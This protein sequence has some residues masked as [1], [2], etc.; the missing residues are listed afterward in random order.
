MTQIIDF[1]INPKNSGFGPFWG[2]KNF[3]GKFGSITHSLI[4]FSSTIPKF[5]KVND[6]IRRKR[7]DRRM[8]GRK[9]GRTDR[10]YF[11]GP[12]RLPP[13]VRKVRSRPKTPGLPEPPRIFGTL[14]THGTSR[15][16]VRTLGFWRSLLTSGNP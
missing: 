10:P 14:K 11:I 6:T 7:P 13:R 16:L 4:W 9:D 5:R 3:P 2:Q 8:E 1:P 12:L 15:D